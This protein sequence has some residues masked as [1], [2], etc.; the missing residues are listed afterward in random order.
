MKRS[1]KKFYKS[2]QTYKYLP[3]KK[4]LNMDLVCIDMDLEYVIL[5]SVPQSKVVF[6]DNTV[7]REHQSTSIDCQALMKSKQL[8]LLI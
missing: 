1:E 6:A 4:E 5:K 3:N 2:S 7:T 8:W